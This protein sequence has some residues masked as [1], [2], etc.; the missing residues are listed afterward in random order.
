M[1]AIKYIEFSLAIEVNDRASFFREAFGNYNSHIELRSERRQDINNIINHVVRHVDLGTGE[2]KCRQCEENY[3]IADLSLAFSEEWLQN[4]LNGMIRHRHDFEIACR[5]KVVP[6]T[7]RHCLINNVIEC[8]ECARLYDSYYWGQCNS[9]RYDRGDRTVSWPVERENEINGSVHNTP[10]MADSNNRCIACD[11]V[12]YGEI[13]DI[14]RDVLDGYCWRCFSHSHIME[15]NYK[16][17]NWK[18]LLHNNDGGNVALYGIEN[19]VSLRNSPAAFIKKAVNS[20]PRRTLLKRD[21]SISTGEGIE[22][23][24]HPMSYNYLLENKKKIAEPYKRKYTNGRVRAD[25]LASCGLHIHVSRNSFRSPGHVYRFALLLATPLARKMSKRRSEYWRRWYMNMER[26]YNDNRYRHV[27][28]TNAHTVEAR[29]FQGTTNP[30]KI[31]KAVEF[32]KLAL[33]ASKYSS[34]NTATEGLM[35]AMTKKYHN[36]YK[37]IVDDVCNYEGSA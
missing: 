36:Q 28:I 24:A 35:I 31:V 14:D 29:I 7:C 2:M 15:W 10:T 22:V 4:E 17:N 32:T 6:I 34:N 16:P 5:V 23:V 27:N 11:R 13:A 19:E 12:I 9:C 3:T 25:R 20:I 37:H 33:E 26:M 1:P 8:G 21:G 18:A 30:N